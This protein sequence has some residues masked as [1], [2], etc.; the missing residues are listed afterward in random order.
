MALIILFP[1]ACVLFV[2]YCFCCGCCAGVAAGCAASLEAAGVGVGAG[3]GAGA[4]AGLKGACSTS[5]IG[6]FFFVCSSRTKKFTFTRPVGTPLS[7]YWSRGC[8]LYGYCVSG[9]AQ[10]EIIN[11]NKKKQFSLI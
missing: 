6:F 8:L 4:G 7:L 11:Y 9:C 2:M 10:T 5:L 3:A 1:V